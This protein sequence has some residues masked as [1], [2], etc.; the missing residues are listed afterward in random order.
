MYKVKEN[1]FVEQIE[2]SKTGKAEEMLQPHHSTVV[3]RFVELVG[4]VIPHNAP[5]NL[6][7][8]QRGH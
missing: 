3:D 6:Y 5:Q 1:S 4:V 8:G 2:E 7:V